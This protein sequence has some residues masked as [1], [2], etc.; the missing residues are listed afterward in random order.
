MTGC[1]CWYPNL[2]FDG[3]ELL[4]LEVVPEHVAVAPLL[5]AGELA[6]GEAPDPAVAWRH[7]QR[8]ATLRGHAGETLPPAE[9]VDRHALEADATHT[10]ALPPLQNGRGC[11]DREERR[12][13]NERSKKRETYNNNNNNNKK[14]E[15]QKER[16]TGKR[17]KDMSGAKEQKRDDRMIPLKYILCTSLLQ[18]KEKQ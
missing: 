18:N 7:A 17:F 8:A 14:A 12:R 2:Q 4:F 1:C 5:L 10:H 16:E 13:R 3:V 11:R 9:V 15:D 6:Q